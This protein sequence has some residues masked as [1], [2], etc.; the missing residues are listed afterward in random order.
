MAR[1]CPERFP[2][3][4]DPLRQGERRVYE[5]LRDQL[6][7]AW[8]AFYGVAWVAMRNGQPADGESDFV[9]AHPDHGVYVVEVKGGGIEYEGRTGHWFSHDRHGQRHPI[10]D[11]FEQGRIGALVLRERLLRLRAWA[12][13]DVD[14]ARFVIFPDSGTKRDLLLHAPRDLI[15][16][17][18]DLDRLPRRL[19]EIVNLFLPNGGWRVPL[20]HER[21]QLLEQLLAQSFRLRL[22]LGKALRETDRRIV[23]LTEQQFS[24]LDMLQRQRRTFVSGAPGTGKT[25]LAVEKARRLARE[26][27]RTLLCCFNRPLGDYLRESVG[28]EPDIVVDTFHSL[29]EKA[30]REAGIEL[31]PNRP[32]APWGSEVFASVLPEALLSAFDRGYPRF[33]AVV[34]DEAQ[35]FVEDWWT[36]LELALHDGTEGV[37][38]AFGDLGQGVYR[39]H[40]AFLER[41][42]PIDL[43]QNLRNTRAIHD[44]ARAF[45]DGR[46]YTCAGP[47]GTPVEWVTAP[48][49][50][51][52]RALCQIL[53]RLIYDEDVPPR[54]IAIVLCRKNSLP[55]D[56]ARLGSFPVSYRSDEDHKVRIDTVH[57]F[58]GLERSAIVLVVPPQI[59]RPDE[60]PLLYIGFTRARGHLVV[61]GPEGVLAGLRG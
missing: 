59:R 25:L 33:D 30:A 23:E 31:P 61:V 35:D 32:D 18:S 43:T 48:T 22:P 58:K 20:G 41:L 2:Y 9:L 55:D 14:P 1:M 54:D 39:R 38:Y 15:V 53:Q 60:D 5:A 29:C 42:T 4:T 51:T 8:V 12:G 16:D 36:T 49:T 3:P 40:S 34:V 19:E 46:P 56:L 52:V 21:I 24:V 17:A 13:T 44:A 28:D 57:R 6:P 11:P 7:R 47:E 45:H 10:K 50:E 37:F 26:G 27:Y